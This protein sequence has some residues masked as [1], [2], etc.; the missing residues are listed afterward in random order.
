MCKRTI[1][2]L[3]VTA[4]IST[5][6]AQAQENA[7][8]V[9]RSG[10][11]VSGQLVDMGGVGFTVRSGGQERNVPTND[12][13]V[14]DFS[15][16]SMSDADWAK[17]NQGQQALWLKNGDVIHGH[18]FDIAG[19]SPLRITF[20]TSSGDREFSSGD[21]AR[22][23]M[24]RPSNAPA[25]TGSLTAPTG[26]G[27]TV[28][29]RQQWTAT[30]ITVRRGEVITFRTTGEIQ[31]STDT[32][33]VATPA[34]SKAARRAAGAPLPDV[35][36]GALIGRINNGRPFGIGTATSVPMPE[37]GQLFL[38]VNDDGLEDNQGEFRVEIQRSGPTRR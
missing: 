27:L 1:L 24:A 14:I 16:G 28:S 15:G 11:R 9:L 21:I 30:G 19:T 6:L 37:A 5:G 36:A 26:S 4:L 29:P 38:G 22:I 34:G 31:L 25:S 17:V 7:T 10:D 18:L 3:S 12:V 20:K 8:L 33:D 23:V 35:L 2:A 32:N 13:A